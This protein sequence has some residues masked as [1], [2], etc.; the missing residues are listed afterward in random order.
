MLSLLRGKKAPAAS[1][2]ATESAGSAADGSYASHATAALAAAA[3]ADGARVAKHVGAGRPVAGE[4]V[5][6]RVD[7]L[8]PGEGREIPVRR[9]AR[10]GR[11]RGAAPP[12]GVRREGGSVCAWGRCLA[13]TS[14]RQRPPAPLHALPLP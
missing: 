5:T 10:G 14:Q 4:S 3:A 1:A 7:E 2:E 13:R 12:M 11:R 6:L 8:L 9:G